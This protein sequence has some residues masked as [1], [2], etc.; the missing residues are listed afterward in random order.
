MFPKFDAHLEMFVKKMKFFFLHFCFCACRAGQQ[1]VRC[2]TLLCSNWFL[3]ES[4]VCEL[5]M[6]G[7]SCYNCHFGERTTDKWECCTTQNRRP[8]RVTWSALTM[9]T[10]QA[11]G[12]CTEKH[13]CV[14]PLYTDRLLA[15][16]TLYTHCTQL[17]TL[18]VSIVAGRVLF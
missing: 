3:N 15:L 14:P 4:I 13:D 12:T 7:S 16:L 6:Q 8:S 11:S 9:Y 17:Q 18:I 10:Y 5:L 1:L 2:K